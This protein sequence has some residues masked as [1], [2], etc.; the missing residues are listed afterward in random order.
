MALVFVLLWAGAWSTATRN[1]IWQD[2]LTLYQDAV[3]QSP[4]FAPAQNQ[5][6]LALNAHNRHDEANEILI[7]N[8]IP[9]GGG[10]SLNAAAALWAQGDYAAARGFLVQYLVDNPGAHETQ[11]LEMLVRMTS[12]Y[13]N[14]ISDETVKRNGYR[15]IL[16]W[17]ERIREISATGFN[18][19]RIGRIHLALG[20]KIAAQQAFAEAARLF[21][22][23]SIYKAPATKLAIDLAR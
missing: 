3:N 4:D 19:Y 20:D 2:N 8:K 21:P 15:N 1:I 13:L 22:P 5:L 7:R 16:I 23:D 11:V 14:G 17:L 10:A 18:Y 6:A 12:E 9:E